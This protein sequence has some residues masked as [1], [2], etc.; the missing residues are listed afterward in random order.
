MD[1][2]TMTELRTKGPHI[3]HLLR[4]GRSV[5]LIHRSQIVGEI[6]PKKP[7]G[8]VLTAKD[9]EELKQLAQE[10]NLPKTSYK[11]R[12]RRYRAHLV[13]KYGQGLSGH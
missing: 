2:I 11:E 8:K 7:S 6:A 10:L 3:L 13:K 1:Y 5:D 9:V 4:Q 12:E